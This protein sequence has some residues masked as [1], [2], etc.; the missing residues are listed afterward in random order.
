MLPEEDLSSRIGESSQS[1]LKSSS[2]P[3]TA[4]GGTHI[5]L[6]VVC[7]VVGLFIFP[8]IFDSVA[9]VLG[10]YAYKKQQGNAGLYVVVAGILC[11][12]IGLYF[13]AQITLGNLLP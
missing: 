2:F 3:S 9:I 7:A 1:P 13:T 12:L 11:M 5:G 4:S 10:A 6:A 8:E